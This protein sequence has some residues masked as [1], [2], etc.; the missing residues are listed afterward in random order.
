VKTRKIQAFLSLAVIA[1]MWRSVVNRLHGTTKWQRWA[2]ILGAGAATGLLIA[3]I[4]RAFI[5]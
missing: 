2:L 3:L 1:G 5:T 4:A